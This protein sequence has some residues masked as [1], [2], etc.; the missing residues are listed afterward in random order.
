MV[1]RN[2]SWDDIPSLADLENQ[3]RQAQGN[4]ISTNPSLLRERLRLPGVFP[5]DNCLLYESN[6]VVKG[7]ALIRPELRIGRTV[8][9]LM[10][11]PD[12][13]EQG[14]ERALVRAALTRAQELRASVLHVQVPK[15]SFWK[16]LLKGEGLKPVHRYW[17]MRWKED[18]PPPIELPEGFS[19]RTYKP[20]DAETLTRIQNAAFEGSWGF[21]PNTPE[22]IQYRAAMSISSPEGILFLSQGD[23]IGGYCWTCVLGSSGEAVGVIS[24]IGIDPAYRQQGLGRPLLSAGIGF[25]C[26]RKVKYIELSV[27]GE[28]DPAIRLYQSVGF[29]KAAEHQW[30]EAHLENLSLAEA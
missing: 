25:L 8:L 20:G 2:F 7:Y 27:D 3:L 22:E 24:M 4:D 19:L 28:N 14:V 9:D 26:S 12:Y 11:Y 29:H 16:K 6:G 18:T 1:I 23:G 21:C 15:G 17:T 30:F 13:S 10:V 5:E